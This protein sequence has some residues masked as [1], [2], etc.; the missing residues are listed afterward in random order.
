[1]KEQHSA[2]K[3]CTAYNGSGS[4]LIAAGNTPQA[5]KCKPWLFSPLKDPTQLCV[6]HNCAV[7]NSLC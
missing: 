3:E 6:A 7:L 1:M 2:P 4:T 5:G